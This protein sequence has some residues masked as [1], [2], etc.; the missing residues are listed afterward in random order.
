MIV[1]IHLARALLFSVLS[2]P[3]IQFWF[4]EYTHYKWKLKILTCIAF[5]LKN[6][7]IHLTR[8]PVVV[9]IK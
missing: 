8:F 1:I 2:D 9:V 4:S 7:L 5:T 3:N 6:S